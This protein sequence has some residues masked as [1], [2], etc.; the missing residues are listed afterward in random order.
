MRQEQLSWV[1]QAWGLSWEESH[2]QPLRAWRGW[3]IH[4]QGCSRGGQVP[5][6]CGQEALVTCRVDPGLLECPHIWPVVSPEQAI[7]KR[8]GRES[9]WP[10]IGGH[11][12]PFLV[13]PAH[14]GEDGKSGGMEWGGEGVSFSSSWPPSFQNS[15]TG[16]SRGH[17]GSWSTELARRGLNFAS[18]LNRWN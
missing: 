7:Q 10:S 11:T 17:L 18:H 12:Q 2:L 9:Q 15:R 8:A 5:A 3:K 16:G 4:C 6:G 14:R 1:I 13:S